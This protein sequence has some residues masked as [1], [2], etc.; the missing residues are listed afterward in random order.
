MGFSLPTPRTADTF[1]QIFNTILCDQQS[2]PGKTTADCSSCSLQGNNLTG[3]VIHF[4]PEA[5]STSHVHATNAQERKIRD[6]YRR[7][8]LRR[9]AR[10]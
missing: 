9:V 4:N 2:T 7:S 6:E 3:R 5:G 8:C 1:L 10:I